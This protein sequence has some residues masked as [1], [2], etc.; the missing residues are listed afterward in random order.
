MSFFSPGVA[1][2]C[3][4][5]LATGPVRCDGRELR[6]E[7][8]VPAKRGQTGDAQGSASDGEKASSEDSDDSDADG[9][10]DE[11]GGTR[12][13]REPR[14]WGA[15]S[16]YGIK[17]QKR[18]GIAGDGADAKTKSSSKREASGWVTVYAGDLPYTLQPDGFKFLLED[19]PGESGAS[20]DL[21]PTKVARLPLFS[22][23]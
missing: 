5:K 1:R 16:Q 11:A 18:E 8:Q 9:N 3:L 22:T 20:A 14:D 10:E 13:K 6:F 2:E 4:A 19:S 23:L 12:V 15:S 17:G 7:M 21:W